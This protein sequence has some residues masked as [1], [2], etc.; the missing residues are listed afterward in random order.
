M[1]KWNNSRL[2]LLPLLILHFGAIS[3]AEEKNE[4]FIAHVDGNEPTRAVHLE[5]ATVGPHGTEER[6]RGYLSPPEH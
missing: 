6:D 4:L 1:D 3:V 2:I 5:P